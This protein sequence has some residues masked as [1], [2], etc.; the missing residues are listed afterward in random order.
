MLFQK[1]SIMRRVVYSLLPLYFLALYL[2]G[3]ALLAHSLLIFG[4]GTGIEYIMAKR[5]KKKVSE[6]VL[7]TCA[8]YTMALPPNTPYWI[9]IVGISFAIL[10]A[11][12]MFGG[13]GRNIFNPAISGRMFI[14][15]TFPTILTTSWMIPGLFGSSGI[16]NVDAITAATPLAMIQSGEALPNLMDLFLGF[17]AGSFGESSS[18][19]IILAGLYLIFTKTA[20]WR[21]MLSSFVSALL[22]TTGLYFGHLIPGLTPDVVPPLTAISIYMMSGSLLFMIVFMTTDPVTSPNNPLAQY[23]Y[24]ALIGAVTIIV[25]TFSVFPEGTSFGIL[26]GNVF[27]NFLDEVLPKKKKGAKKSASA[28]PKTQKQEANV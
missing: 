11:K 13:F 8:L 21:L 9:A 16:K 4:A 22:C 27:A 24:G 1:Q 15:L 10:V 25:R 26:V 23:C 2:Y 12:E 28:A 14:Y 5:R 19:L 18:L 6:A 20:N 3:W 7:V 17:R